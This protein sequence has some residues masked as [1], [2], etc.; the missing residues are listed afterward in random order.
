MT[1]YQFECG[2]NSVNHTLQPSYIFILKVSQTF[3]NWKI[4]IF[5]KYVLVYHVRSVIWP[6]DI[7][8]N[9]IAEAYAFCI[10]NMLML[11]NYHV[12]SSSRLSKHFLIAKV[13]HGKRFYYGMYLDYCWKKISSRTHPYHQKYLGRVLTLLKAFQLAQGV[14]YF[15][16]CRIY[17][18]SASVQILSTVC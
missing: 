8:R 10:K 6:K 12:L 13:W 16:Y 3:H 2:M 4:M 1:L 14:K 5:K 17:Q 7:I 15:Y 11:N 9:I 18:I